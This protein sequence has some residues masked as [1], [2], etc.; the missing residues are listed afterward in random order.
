MTI[1]LLKLKNKCSVVFL[2]SCCYAPSWENGSSVSYRLMANKEAFVPAAD[3]EFSWTMTLD[4]SD[5]LYKTMVLFQSR[6]PFF[7]CSK[8]VWSETA[9]AH[10]DH[11]TCLRTRRHRSEPGVGS[12]VNARWLFMWAQRQWAT[13]LDGSE[14]L[15]RRMMGVYFSG[16]DELNG[17]VLLKK[18]LVHRTLNWLS[19]FHWWDISV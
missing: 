18:L 14:E 2:A 1:E 15:H 10:S 12:G 16:Q 7:F 5:P 4:G 9:P 19:A 13:L 17:S 3:Q 8:P 6:L 11:E